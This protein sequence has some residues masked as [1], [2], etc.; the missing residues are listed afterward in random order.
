[1][2]LLLLLGLSEQSLAERV[3]MAFADTIPPYTIP[4][5]GRGIELE[6]VREA[7]ALKGHELEASFMPLS[8]MPGS[9]ILGEVDGVMSD[10]GHDLSGL[11]GH[12]GNPVVL[13]NN[14]FFSVKSR[15]LIIRDPKDIKGLS[16]VAFPGAAKRFP[17]WLA[18]IKADGNY[19]EIEQQKLQL[20]LLMSGRYDLVLSDRVV[21]YYFLNQQVENMKV[22]KSALAEHA[23]FVERPLDYRPVF[24]SQKIR[25]DFAEGL[26]ALKASGRY[27]A[28]YE[29][30]VSE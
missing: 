5:T 13:F 27:Q 28:I 1:M 17:E 18:D 3:R 23:V 29:A 30:Y 8:R 24:K 22:E 19:D 14:R 25:D 12:Y 21:F 16:V 6:I 2:L 15:N 9:F 26:Q 7:L 20:R 10:F 11:N 4:E